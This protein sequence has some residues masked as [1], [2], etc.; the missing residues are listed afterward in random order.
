MPTT[1]PWS[2]PYALA[3]RNVTKAYPGVVAL[4]DVTFDV[5]PGEVHALVG[6]NGAGKSTLM[7][8]V[9]GATTPDTGS[10]TICGNEVSPGDPRISAEA[11]LAMIYQELTI[12]PGLTAAQ[13]VFLGIT[14]QRLGWVQRA[15]MRRRFDALQQ[16]V[17]VDIDPDTPAGEL[18]VPKQRILEVMR[19][20]ARDRR[21]VVMD[22]PTASLGQDD[23][24]HLQSVVRRL[25]A[26]GRAVVYI[27]H[28]LDEVM[29]LADRIS[30]M[31]E[32][33]LIATGPVG[34]WTK[35]TLVASM[36]GR[37]L[38]TLGRRQTTAR[39]DRELVIVEDLV[40]ANGSVSVRRLEIR[41]GE[42]LGLG[43]LIGSGRT[44]LL[45]ALAGADST[46][47]GQMTV[48]GRRGAV[49]RSVP[50]GLRRGLAL[51]P[52]ERQRQGLCLNR[53]AAFNILLGDLSRGGRWGTY[54]PGRARESATGAARAMGFDT[55][56]L[57][58]QAST[59]SGGNQ[60]K[61][62]LARWLVRP[63]KVLMLDEPSRGIDLGAKAEIFSAMRSLA[64]D[65]VA[66][67]MVSSDLEEV[68]NH[69]DR[70][71]VMAQ[72][73]VVTELVAPV[74]V[75]DILGAAFGVDD[76]SPELPAGRPEEVSS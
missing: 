72:G 43:G 3:A 75:S 61:I 65:G 47:R 40:A 23:R 21:V 27:S 46:A 19:A 67:V 44:E 17:A 2:G 36:L 63:P 24:E 56:R 41:A 69:C 73:T 15:A 34:G 11:G 26:G 49:P 53:T 10:I 31:R 42:I 13:N 51:V 52:E 1:D 5:A 9:S 33:R 30:V 68:A 14:P 62:L 29:A 35:R 28:D 20:L 7:K 60:Q 70:V 18:P 4:D 55:R 76:D 74:N 25:R 54:Q 16:E 32:G 71:A 50:A 6:E 39:S 8:V 59:F 57:G 37:E 48:E 38:E 66:I 64:D 45:R 12:V 22:E 58:Q